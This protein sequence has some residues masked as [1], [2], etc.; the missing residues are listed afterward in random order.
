MRIRAALNRDIGQIDKLFTDSGFKLDIKHLERLIVAEDDNGK[1]A[2]VLYLNTV[3][4][5]TFLTDE[6]GV[7]R[8]KRVNSLKLLVE[9]GK[10]EVKAIGFDLVHAFANEK[11]A[12]ILEKHFGFEQGKGKNLILFTE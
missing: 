10:K 8:K 2:G 3:L 6:K 11:I 12:P 7:S 5:C 1:I 4:E 9:Q